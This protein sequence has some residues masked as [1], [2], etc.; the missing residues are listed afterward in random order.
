MALLIDLKQPGWMDEEELR[1]DLLE[2]YPQGDIRCSAAPGNLDDIEVL[3]V[4]SY[5]SGDALR[6]P[7]LKLIQKT[8]AGVESILADE[9]LPETI[10]VARLVTAVPAHEIAEYCLAAVLQEQ[11]H[12]RVYSKNQAEW[13]WRTTAPRKA[14]ETIIAVL[15]LGMIGSIVAQRFLSNRFKVIGWSR[16]EKML[17]DVDCY[18]GNDQLPTVLG[19]ADYVVAILPSTP[20]TVDLFDH[21]RFSLMKPESV[22]INCGRGDLIDEADLVEALDDNRLSAAILDVMQTEPLPVN[23]PFWKHPKVVLTPHVSGWHLG[24][25]IKDIAENMRRL[26]NGEALMHLVNRQLGY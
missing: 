14:D 3:A 15:G 9:S 7:N 13:C 5:D 24:D 17:A 25:A 16:G 22:L 8:G 19:L 11:R 20:E 18:H 4:S 23:S 2:C 6:Y 1:Q 21:E 26:E 10:Q 12:F